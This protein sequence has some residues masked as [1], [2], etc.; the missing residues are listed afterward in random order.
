M[1]IEK[2]LDY[3]KRFFTNF[4]AAWQDHSDLDLYRGIDATADALR[5]DLSE[6]P[7]YILAYDKQAQSELRA[8]LQKG[9]VEWLQTY[10]PFFEV[11]ADGIVMFGDWYHRRQFGVLDVWTRQ[12]MQYSDAE[13]QILPDLETYAA[14]PENYLKKRLANLHDEAYSEADHLQSR[15]EQAQ[16]AVAAE[17]DA[18]TRSSRERSGGGFKGL[19]KNFIDQ[20]EDEA[21]PQS[22]Q[23]DSSEVASLQS[24]LKAARAEAQARYD[25]EKRQI[26]VEA[27]V[28]NYEYQA[29]IS[30]YSSLQQFE[31]SLQHIADSYMASLAADPQLAAQKESDDDNA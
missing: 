16:A 1:D 17:P 29:I 9:L 23:T 18:L 14:D 30:Q 15:L 3:Q 19:M 7:G 31:N 12:I 24:Q 20:P 13:R 8:Y 11:S 26:Q 21:A 28:T 27:A 6:V 22:S 5:L 25:E 10:I 2:S 4:A